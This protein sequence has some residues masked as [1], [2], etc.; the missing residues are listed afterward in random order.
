MFTAK[1]VGILNEIE[2]FN[3][4]HQGQIWFRGLKDHSNQLHSGIFR[5]RLDSIDK[6][7][8]L[9][10]QLYA[11][12]KN[13]GYTLHGGDS[14]WSLL[15][16]M[17]HYGVKT[18]LLDWTE[19][20]SV[21]LFFASHGWETGTCRIW[22]INPVK[23][24]LLSISREEIISPKNLNYLET[25]TTKLD[26]TSIAIYP[27]KNNSRLTAQSGVFTVQGNSMLSLEKEF[28]SELIKQNW[29]KSIDLTIDV[30]EDALKYLDMNNVNYFS[31]FPDLTGLAE[32][33]N[34]RFIPPAWQ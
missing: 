21:A 8:N 22:M 3:Q 24:N 14:G 31:L 2:E 32:H 17:Q 11:Y 33:L 30:K 4:L 18:R 28:N 34:Y 15:Y 9:E 25:F 13:L 23:L 5:L 16:C 7:I 19:S 29:L 27:M 6:I 26:Q 20:F 10:N 1:W 12:F